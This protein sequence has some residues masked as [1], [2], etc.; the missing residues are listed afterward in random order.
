MNLVIKRLFDIFI[1]ITLIIIFIPIWVLL[2]VSAIIVQKNFNIFYS[3]I[4]IF[5]NLNKYK[6]YKFRTMVD[7]ANKI[8]DINKESKMGNDFKNTSLDSNLFTPFGKFLERFQLNETL[9]FYLILIGRMS[10]V[11]NRPLPIN[12]Y[13][14][15]NNNFKNIK[16]IFSSPSGLTGL[17]Q[18]VGKR[19]IST[20]E[21][22]NLENEYCRIYSEGINLL[23]ID[24][25]IIFLTVK[26]LLTNKYI[27]KK[28][29]ISL[30]KKY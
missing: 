15:L 13:D 2:I 27:D 26:V 22:I 3:D 7:D 6:I 12:I 30:I 20:I 5:K 14:H 4:R 11:G 9:Q 1:S 19:N 24:M 28:N 10:F 29:I 18:I 21:R 8:I 17:S 25:I 16:N 23:K